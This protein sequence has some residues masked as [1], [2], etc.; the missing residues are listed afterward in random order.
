MFFVIFFK[1]NKNFFLSRPAAR[2]GQDNISQNFPNT[3]STSRLNVR[4]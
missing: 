1:N 3:G 4:K 2:S